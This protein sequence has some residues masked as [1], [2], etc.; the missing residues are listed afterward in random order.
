ML[1]KAH[2]NSSG[3]EPFLHSRAKMFC[4]FACMLLQAAWLRRTLPCF[5]A[6]RWRGGA[7]MPK[8][9][10]C[11]KCVQ[12]ISEGQRSKAAAEA[13][14]KRPGDQ[15]N[16]LC[17]RHAREEGVAGTEQLA[18]AAA[19]IKAY[20]QGA[21]AAVRKTYA[22]SAERQAVQEAYEQGAGVAVREAYEQGAGVA[23][24]EVYRQSAECQAVREAYEQS[25]E[26]QAVREAYE[27]GAERQAVQQR[28]AELRACASLA[29]VLAPI[30]EDVEADPRWEQAQSVDEKQ[31][32]ID[33]VLSTVL[34]ETAVVSAAANESAAAVM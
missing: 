7:T 5:P 3:T 1:P 14:V 26:C 34:Q 27:Q 28:A 11:E 30:L 24:R 31:A 12:L 17:K 29:L 22:Q 13:R 25:A 19:T 10:R 8:H 32:V 4:R 33:D 15:R 2:P 6:A 20:E 18:K 21:G 9:H 16:T 23:V